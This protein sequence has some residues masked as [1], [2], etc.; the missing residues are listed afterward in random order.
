MTRDIKRQIIKLPRYI[1]EYAISIFN[2]CSYAKL[3]SPYRK[4]FVV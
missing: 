2:K 4:Q 3:A 1:D